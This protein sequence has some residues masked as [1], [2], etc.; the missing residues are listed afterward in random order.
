[1]VVQTGNAQAES[2][3]NAIHGRLVN[4]DLQNRVRDRIGIYPCR[5]SSSTPTEGPFCTVRGYCHHGLTLTIRILIINL[6][7]RGEE[8]S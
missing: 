3:S 4:T 2:L 8:A 1:V 5:A 7:I 6:K